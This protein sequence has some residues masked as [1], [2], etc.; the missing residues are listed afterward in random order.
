VVNTMTQILSQLPCAAYAEVDN[1]ILLHGLLT[2]KL[3]YLIALMLRLLLKK[4]F[5][6]L[7]RL[8]FWAAS[9]ISKSLIIEMMKA[10]QIIGTITREKMIS[11]SLKSICHKRMEIFILL[12]KP[13]TT[14]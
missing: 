8:N 5:S 12:S 1:L 2:T 3:K 7:I 11:N 9:M 4:E 13:I 6:S 10:S 14:I